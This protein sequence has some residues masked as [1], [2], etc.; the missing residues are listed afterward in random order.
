MTELPDKPGVWVREG[1][2][3]DVRNMLER[4]KAERS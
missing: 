4:L 3:L 2:L 1:V